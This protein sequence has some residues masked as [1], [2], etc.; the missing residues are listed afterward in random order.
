M[1]ITP[2]SKILGVLG[3]MG[4]AASA[5]FMRLV[6][7]KAP[8]GKDQE[9]PIVYLLS[10]SQVPDRGE[11]VSGQGPDPTARLKK[12]LEQL[13]S[14]GADVLAT[15]CN[16]AHVFIDTFYM[17][18]SKPYLHIVKETIR[19]CMNRSPQGAWL[20]ATTATCGTGLYDKHA[21]E[22]GYTFH[23]VTDAVQKRVQECVGLVKAA[24]MEEAG[25]LM[26]NVVEGLWKEK[27]ILVAT[28]CT[29][30]PLAYDA[31]GLPAER[32][33]SSLAALSDACL[34]YLYP[35]IYKRK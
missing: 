15:P 3:G 6:T 27:N 35:G 7:L 2:P 10:D 22:M 23:H 25:A 21:K 18:L 17:G 20:L 31:S 11:A 4:P 14:W 9:H 13:I 16:T 29:E 24:K 32:N 33:V 30:L 26:R 28:A 1:A 19:S 12:D 34:E 5:E 8:A